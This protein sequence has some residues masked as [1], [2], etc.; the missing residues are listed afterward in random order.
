MKNST[1]KWCFYYE[2]FPVVVD[3]KTEMF[4]LIFMSG[5]DRLQHEA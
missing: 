2:P 1:L 3:H 5:I 4:K